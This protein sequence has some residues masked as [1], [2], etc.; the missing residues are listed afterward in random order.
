MDYNTLKVYAN[1]APKAAPAVNLMQIIAIVENALMVTLCQ[2]L[3]ALKLL[4]PPDV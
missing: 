4:Q 1:N 3:R 2:E